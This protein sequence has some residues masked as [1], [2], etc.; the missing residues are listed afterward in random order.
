MTGQHKSRAFSV[1]NLIFRA[2]QSVFGFL[3]VILTVGCMAAKP[4]E[5]ELVLTKDVHSF[6]NPA[7]ARVMHVALDLEADF[8]TKQLKGKAEL[9]L[10][11]AADAKH[12]ILDTRDLEILSVTDASGSPLKFALGPKDEALG[13]ALSIELPQG[14]QKIVVSYKT[15]PKASALQWLEPSQTAGKTKPFLLSQGQEIHT[16][17]WIPTQDSPGIRQ[18][19]Q[20]RIVVPEALSAVMSAQMLTPKGEAVAGD[21]NKKA[22]RFKMTEPIA[23]YLI[24]IAIGDIGFKPLSHR[25]GVYAETVMIDKAAYEF[26]E[27]EKMLVATESLYGPYRWGRYD[28][29]VLPPSFPYGGMEN[30]R[31]TFLTPT[32]LTGDRSLVSLIAHEMAHSW[33]GNLVTNATWSDFWLNEGFTVYI[34]NRIMEEVYDKQTADMLKVLGEQELEATI[35]DILKGPDPHFS[36]LSPDLKGRNPDDYFSDVPYEKGAALIRLLEKQFGRKKLDAWLK[37]YFT[38]NAFKSVTTEDFLKDL[39]QNLLKN[40]AALEESLK[41]NEWI[42]GNGMPSNA[43]KT[44]SEAFFLIDKDLAAL[45]DKKLPQLTVTKQWKTQQ[46]QY[47]LNNLPEGLTNEDLIA[48]DEAFMLSQSTNA[49]IQFSW[50]QYAIKA[51]YEPA[52]LPMEAFLKAQGRRKFVAPLYKSL[53]AQKGWGET[54]ARRI[55]KEA[56]PSYHEVTRNTVDKTISPL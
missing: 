10:K 3:F 52:L 23:P 32:I 26:A 29:L 5:A 22:F 1:K 51:R 50:Y 34:E 15:S 37:G 25:T 21:K 41:L 42:Y 16:R 6:A 55:Y 27:M 38:R 39:R 12:V 33:S 46:W 4:P 8:T 17:T 18:T 14:A 24:A 19:Y 28:V 56:R 47:F 30:P 31:L 54:L 20:A 53:M 13:Q 48:L 11:T 36:R 45:K 43:I 44:S 9:T 49:E 7:E 35:G 2:F 40:D